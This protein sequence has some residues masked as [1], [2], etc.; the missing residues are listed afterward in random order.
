MRGAEAIAGVLL[1]A[2]TLCACGPAR[3]YDG[4]ARPR[5]EVAV[6]HVVG[7]GSA[8]G[9]PGDVS[10]DAQL[11]AIDGVPYRGAPQVV[12]VLPGKHT[13]EVRWTRSWIPPAT[14]F[15]DAYDGTTLWVPM[16]RGTVDLE[17]EV[18]AG[19]RYELVWSKPERRARPIGFRER[20]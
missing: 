11:V 14:G 4:P 5:S 1:V 12:Q 17:I 19:R 13:L 10:T 9:Y 18:R 6:L 20:R 3:T 7:Y 2:L 15:G 16:S 8:T